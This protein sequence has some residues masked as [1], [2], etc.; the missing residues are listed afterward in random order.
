MSSNRVLTIAAGRASSTGTVTVTAQDNDI[1]AVDKTVTV[2]GR[3]GQRHGRHR[4]AGCDAR[5]RGR[6]RPRCDRVGRPADLQRRRHR[7]VHGEAEHGADRLGDGGDLGP[8]GHGPDPEQDEAAVHDD[9]L[10]HGADGAGDGG[11]GRRR[12]GRH[13]DA[14]AR[15]VRGRR[16]RLRRGEEEPAGADRRR[17]E[18]AGDDRRSRGGHGEGGRA[19]ALP[20]HHVEAR[21]R[22]E[23]RERGVRVQLPGGIS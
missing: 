17:R 9:E 10:V 5:H 3:C 14:E 12:G 18:A 21:Y 6:R 1:D 16:G 11:P 15:G 22:P 23:L 7:D 2:K 8:F 13:G 20:D 4:P 19:G